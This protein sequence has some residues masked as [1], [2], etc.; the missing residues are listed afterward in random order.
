M[1]RENTSSFTPQLVITLSQLILFMQLLIPK[2]ASRFLERACTLNFE[3]DM[4]SGSLFTIA[5]YDY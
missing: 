1:W 3:N 5:S 2:R 4:K